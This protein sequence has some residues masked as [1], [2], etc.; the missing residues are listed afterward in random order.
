MRTPEVTD[1]STLRAVASQVR[2]DIY[3]A[4]TVDGP[5]TATQLAARF[6]HQ[7]ASMSYHLRTLARHG[8]VAEAPELAADRRERVWRAV[9]GGVRWSRLDS[10]P[11]RDEAM[12]TAER[13]MLGRQVARLQN[14]LSQ[15][16]QWPSQ[17]TDASEDVDKLVHLTASET[18]QMAAEVMGVLNKW[19][20][21]ARVGTEDTADEVRTVMV[22][23]HAFPYVMEVGAPHDQ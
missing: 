9:P 4:L 23:F 12:Q 13:V 14:W 16:D 22:L 8:F 18:A 17:W 6:G 21:R 2:L 15:R 19:S 11:G 20:T 5:A 10:S 3:E 7:T 1:A